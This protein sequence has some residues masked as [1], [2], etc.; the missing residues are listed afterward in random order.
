MRETEMMS[1][2]DGDDAALP[3]TS[4]TKKKNK[5]EKP[6]DGHIGADDLIIFFF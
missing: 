5:N 2:L 6:D 3:L 1:L 4:I